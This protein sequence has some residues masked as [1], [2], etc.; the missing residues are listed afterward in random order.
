MGGRV[1]LYC[2]TLF[3]T[4]ENNQVGHFSMAA[5]VLI[6]P[7]PAQIVN[8]LASFGPFDL[9]T[10][11]QTED[12]GVSDLR[13]SASL[14]SGEPL[15]KGMIL[16]GDG[17]L[18]GIPG[19]NTQGNY[20]VLVT[21]E[22]AD[23]KLEE[24][25][26]FTIKPSMVNTEVNYLDKLKSQVWDALE[27]QLPIPDMGSLLSLPITKLD[28]YYLLERWGTLTVWDAFNLDPP[29]E[30]QLLDIKGVSPHYNVYD[31]GSSLIMCPK[32]LFSTDRTIADGLQTARAMAGEIY[33]RGWTI[34]MAGL[35]K[36]TRAAWVELQLL[37]DQHGKHIEI[38]N[39]QPTDDELMLYEMKAESMVKNEPE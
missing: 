2:Y 20:E 34:E 8:E 27:Q 18:T 37:G 16:T 12:E 39:Y 32:D 14:K 7:I 31:R 26:V 19:Q 33:S 15:P 1:G 4:M 9:K 6:H 22:N 38:I 30:K 28:I 23:G 21:A 29:H 17:I 24:S 3:I 35:D 5:P 13:F 36:W 25:F 11:I 10:F